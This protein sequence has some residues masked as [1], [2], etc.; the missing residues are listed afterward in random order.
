AHPQ[1]CCAAPAHSYPVRDQPA[2][3]P[4]TPDRHLDTY[5]NASAATNSQAHEPAAAANSHAGRHGDTLT[6]AHSKHARAPADGHA[7]SYNADTDAHTVGN[8]HTAAAIHGHTN[9]GS[10][11]DQ[12]RDPER[13][14]QPEYDHHCVG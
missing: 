8:S 4:N 7:H 5:E 2:G 1:L 13:R 11:A 12:L 14:L 6:T 10:D 9:T 3:C